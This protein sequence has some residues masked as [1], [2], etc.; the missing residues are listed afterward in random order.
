MRVGG[1]QTTAIYERYAIRT[2]DDLLA[3]ARQLR[4]DRTVGSLVE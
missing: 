3:A 4:Q 2:E 1:Y